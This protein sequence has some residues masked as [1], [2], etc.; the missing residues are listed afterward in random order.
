MLL[1]PSTFRVEEK[2][3]CDLVTVDLGRF[4]TTW[5]EATGKSSSQNQ[6]T[7][8][9]VLTASNHQFT[10][11]PR[12]KSSVSV[13]GHHEDR[14]K[15]NLSLTCFRGVVWREESNG[16]LLSWTEPCFWVGPDLFLHCRLTSFNLI[17]GLC[18]LAPRGETGDTY[19]P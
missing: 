18:V 6:R 16:H 11:C 15:G 8:H 12:L 14:N 2:A 4:M 7:V 19:M 9:S 1:N 17:F 3:S 5:I 13:P 10:S